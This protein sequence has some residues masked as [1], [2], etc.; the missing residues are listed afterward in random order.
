MKKGNGR[1]KKVDHKKQEN[2]A[3]TTDIEVKNGDY[4]A[5]YMPLL[6]EQLRYHTYMDIDRYCDETDENEPDNGAAKED[7]ERGELGEDEC[8]EANSEVNFRTETPDEQT[9]V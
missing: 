9:H 3:N 1:K 6:N 4:K 8:N 7:K 2:Q 5:S